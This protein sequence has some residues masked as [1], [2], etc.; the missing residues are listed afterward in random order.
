MKDVVELSDTQVTAQVARL[1]D[2]AQGAL[3]QMQHFLRCVDG[4]QASCR[5]RLSEDGQDFLIQ[6]LTKLFLI[7]LDPAGQPAIET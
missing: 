3:Q 4:G 2:T 1:L 6:R 7:S 5:L